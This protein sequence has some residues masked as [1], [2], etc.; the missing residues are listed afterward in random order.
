MCFV[1]KTYFVIYRSVN[2]K[3]TIFYPY[4]SG[5][6]YVGV[7]AGGGVDGGFV[8]WGGCGIVCHNFT[9]CTDV[10]KVVAMDETIFC[11]VF[12]LIRGASWSIVSVTICVAIVVIVVHIFAFLNALG[13]GS[14]DHGCNVCTGERRYGR[15]GVALTARGEGCRG[16]ENY[17]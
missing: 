7:A 6:L 8:L 11:G 17:M 9:F 13:M 1:W 3:R 12:G 10:A 16:M 5:L 14:F 2:K 15:V 4:F